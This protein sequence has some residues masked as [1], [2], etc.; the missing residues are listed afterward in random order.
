MG[1]E[2]TAQ[3][4]AEIITTALKY[5]L[6]GHESVL[7]ELGDPTTAWQTRLTFGD[8]Q[9]EVQ[10]LRTG[11]GQWFELYQFQIPRHIALRHAPRW[12]SRSCENALYLAQA[13]VI[14][15]K[16]TKKQF[17]LDVIKAAPEMVDLL[18]EVTSRPRTP[19]HPE[20][21]T[22]ETAC[23]CLVALFSFPTDVV[24]GLPFN[25]SDTLQ[26]RVA[27]EEWEQTLRAL[28]I[29]ASRQGYREGIIRMFKILDEEEPECILRS[30]DALDSSRL[31][32]L[33]LKI[34]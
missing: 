34:G 5:A 24:P 30:V 32:A 15:R 1:E 12:Y 3:R 11:R 2:L 18:F 20:S 6:I 8:G 27:K 33:T 16:K 23:E 22:Q 10:L 25:Y 17:T 26:D 13:L 31:T 21:C 9:N 14:Q 4:T 29:L 19:W 28:E 7:R